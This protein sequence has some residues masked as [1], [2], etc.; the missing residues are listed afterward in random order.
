MREDKLMEEIVSLKKA[1]QEQDVEKEQISQMLKQAEN[2]VTDAHNQGRQE[3][4][5]SYYWQL[6]CK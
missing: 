4:R 6:K 5:V 2:R 3:G 1:R